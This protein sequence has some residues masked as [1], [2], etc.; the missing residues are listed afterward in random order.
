MPVTVTN[1]RRLLLQLRRYEAKFG[2]LF[3]F[4]PPLTAFQQSFAW[5]YWQQR[6]EVPHL[7]L[8]WRHAGLT[9]CFPSISSPRARKSRKYKPNASQKTHQK[10]NTNANAIEAQS[11]QNPAA[12]LCENFHRSTVTPKPRLLLCAK[13]LME[14]QSPQNPA[15][16]LCE[17]SHRSTVPP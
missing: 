17:N 10:P 9:H 5:L 14:A 1:L 15:A 8:F 16:S 2:F 11:P 6:I 13:L 4:A 7:L 12:S 3:L